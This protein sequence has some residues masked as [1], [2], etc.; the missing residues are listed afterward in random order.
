MNYVGYWIPGYSTKK[1]QYI[2]VNSYLEINDTRQWKK[3][4]MHMFGRLGSTHSCA[5][6]EE[7]MIYFAKTIL[8]GKGK[9]ELN[10]LIIS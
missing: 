8:E 10:Q 4:H 1:S 6:N 2:K 9:K 3:W 5:E 7:S